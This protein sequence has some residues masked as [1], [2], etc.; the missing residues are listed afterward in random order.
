MLL[1]MAS[2]ARRSPAPDAL[3]AKD[4]LLGHVLHAGHGVLVVHILD[5]AGHAQV[6][7]SAISWLI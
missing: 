2:G 6:A 1:L 5:L 3:L 4:V 7:F